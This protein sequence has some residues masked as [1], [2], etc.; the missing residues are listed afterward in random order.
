MR[1]RPAVVL[2]AVGLDLVAGEPPVRW[3]PVVWIG[4]ALARAEARAAC[5]TVASGAAAVL[6]VT[7]TAW[8]VAAGAGMV[9]R[10][11]GWAGT[12][13]EAVALKPTFAVR[14]LAGAAG[15][16]RASLETG[17]LGEAQRR[18][19]RHLVSRVTEELDAALVTSAVVESVAENLADSVAGPLLAYAA[20]GLPAAWVYRTLNTA[21]AMWGYRD[22]RY[23]RFG[24]AAARLDDV[25]NLL[26]ARV[27]AGAIVAGAALAGE[28]AGAA[29]RVAWRDHGRTASPNAG[30]P[31]AALAGAL[32]LGLAKPG[33]YRLGD[34]VLPE[35]P[36]TI[37]RAVWVFG[38]AATLVVGAAWALALGRRNGR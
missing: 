36:E 11:L 35:S 14:R 23:E 20:G 19:G 25:A 26:P 13:L 16:V 38:A 10:R 4:R 17:D 21:D 12:L 31:M 28:D 27:A 22:A 30:W 37:R 5:R 3:H 34:G 29:A 33:A 15:E 32:G 7:A 18:L 1:P 2:L 24:K 9:L 6:A 8:A